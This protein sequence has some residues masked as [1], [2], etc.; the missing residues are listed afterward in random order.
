MNQ[1]LSINDLPVYSPWP[2]RLLCA[3]S[4]KPRSKSLSEVLREYQNEK[5]TNLLAFVRSLKKPPVLEDVFQFLDAKSSMPCLVAGELI[6]MEPR[7]A[8]IANIRALV[9]FIVGMED[10]D[11][12]TSVLELGAGF[13]QII[14]S[15]AAEPA[16]DGKSF[17]GAE[18]T[19]SGCELIQLLSTSSTMNVKSCDF[20]SSNI[21]DFEL[22]SRSLVFTSYA[23]CYLENGAED[24][25]LKLIRHFPARV[26]HFEPIYETILDTTL[27]G[28]MQKKYIEINGYNRNL[29]GALRQL[30]KKGKIRILEEKRELFAINPFFPPSLL[31]WEPA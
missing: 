25:L 2:A 31:V 24:F 3:N 29:W 13:G 9:D 27:L 20:Y 30:E 16:L 17:F 10:L 8:R 1:T 14:L 6:L 23:A 7:K 18:L 15:L 11:V 12:F 22:P 19:Q 5:W 28:L 26:I 21:F 4:W